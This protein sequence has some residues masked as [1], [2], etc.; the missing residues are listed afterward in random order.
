[1]RVFLVGN[2][3]SMVALSIICLERIYS[4]REHASLTITLVGL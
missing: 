3:N 4:M 2:K 1:M